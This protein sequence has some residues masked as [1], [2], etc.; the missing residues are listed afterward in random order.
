[1]YYIVNQQGDWLLPELQWYRA[2]PT[3]TNQQANAVQLTE[4]E[5]DAMLLHPRMH[6]GSFKEL[7]A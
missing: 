4:A 2:R 3:F 7:V 6:P 1:M 5:A